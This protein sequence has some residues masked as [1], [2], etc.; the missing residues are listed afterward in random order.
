MDRASAKLSVIPLL[1]V[2][3]LIPPVVA[4]VMAETPD[5]SIEF[6]STVALGIP[7]L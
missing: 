4:R 1:S 3:E 7:V 5:E 2:T 6:T